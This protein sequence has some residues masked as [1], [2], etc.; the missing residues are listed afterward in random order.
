MAIAVH[1]QHVDFAGS[2]ERV[3]DTFQR[4]VHRGKPRLTNIGGHEVLREQEIARLVAKGSNVERR[5]L[6]IALRAAHR[7][8]PP[9]EAPKPFERIA[10]VKIGG[11]A[12]AALEN[13]KAKAFELVQ[14]TTIECACRHGRN[15]ARDEIGDKRVFLENGRIAPP[16]WPI[17]LRNHRRAVFHTDLVHA[18]LIAVERQHAAIS[19][20]A[21]SGQHAIER[22]E[23]TFRR[24]PGEG[25]SSAAREIVS[26]FVHARIV[27]RAVVCDERCSAKRA[28]VP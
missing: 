20:H 17:E 28:R 12:A 8:N 23:H 14:R 11:T 5:P 26:F 18:V 21:D 6:D 9:D 22:V 10:P 19:A 25:D 16:L 27:R 1:A 4:E 24:K 15:F 2:L 3:F 7:V 13:R